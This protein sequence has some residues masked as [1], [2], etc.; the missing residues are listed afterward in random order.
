M[1][2][3][4]LSCDV[5]AVAVGNFDGM[6]RGHQALFQAAGPKGGIAVIEHFASILTPHIFRSEYTG[7]PLFFYDFAR[8]K[9]LSPEQFVA[10]LKHDFPLL[11]RI[12]VGE[13]FRFGANRSGDA[14]L[15]A[16]LFDREVCIVPEK[17]C[18]GGEGIHSRTIRS[19][20]MQ[21]NLSKAQAMLGRP[22]AIWGKRVVGQG[23]G[24]RSL[25]PT[26]NLECG[27]F[28]LPKEGVYA[29]FTLINGRIYRSVSFIGRRLTTDGNFS[30][31]THILDAYADEPIV[32]CKVVWTAY[33]RDN[34]K[35]TNLSA[36][37]QQI[38]QDRARA[39]EILSSEPVHA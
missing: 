39:S 36:L 12:V 22:Y 17:R 23:L 26:I 1:S 21:G 28:L 30:V 32:R 29:T 9:T 5:E 35:F 20:L 6:H 31:E 16:K 13:D 14:A 2:G 4:M 19:F 10:R 18:E 38:D 3:S 37:K 7:L 33:L 15:L 11:K 25:V 27:R 24:K 34:K 8:I